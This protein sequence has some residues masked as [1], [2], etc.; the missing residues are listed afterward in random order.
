MAIQNVNK[1]KRKKRESSL[2]KPRLFFEWLKQNFIKNVLQAKFLQSEVV[3]WLLLANFLTNL[4][5]WI[6]LAIFIRPIDIDIILHYN[7][8]FGVD[9]MGSWKQ[10]FLL[11]VIG[12]ILLTI[13]TML[14]VYFYQRKKIVASYILLLATLMVQINLVVASMSVIIINH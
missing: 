4:V 7:I 12:L 11:P 1:K 3:D 14:A 5:N 13:N 9:A 2:G 10:V 8:Y 6:L